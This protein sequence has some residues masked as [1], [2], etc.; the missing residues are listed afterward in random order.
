MHVYTPPGYETSQQKYP[1]LYLH[2]GGGES[3]DSWG[4]VG[5]AGFILDNLIADGKAVPMIVVMPNAHTILIPPDADPG[6]DEYPNE[7]MTDVMPYVE[8]HYRVIA[9]REHRAIAGLSSGGDQSMTIGLWRIWIRS[10]GS[11]SSVPTI[12]AADRDTEQRTSILRSL[13]RAFTRIRR[14]PTRKS[15]CSKYHCG[16][17]DE[18]L[19]FQKRAVENFQNHNIK[20][21][22]TAFPGGTN[23]KCFGARWPISLPGYSDR[24]NPG[25]SWS[26]V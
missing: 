2:H 9:D 16:T 14:R 1:V 13:R 3:D 21:M 11:P 20:V 15:N 7:F 17:E 25:G 26:F 10:P 5:R 19:P 8:S 24:A 23:G 18:R 22:F 6:P 12:L 4:T